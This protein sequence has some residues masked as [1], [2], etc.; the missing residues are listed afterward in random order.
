[1]AITNQIMIEIIRTP[2]NVGDNHI[3]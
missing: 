1:M 2:I 3:A